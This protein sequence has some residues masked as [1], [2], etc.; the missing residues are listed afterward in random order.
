MPEYYFIQSLHTEKDYRANFAKIRDSRTTFVETTVRH[1]DINHGIYIDIFPLDDCYDDEKRQQKRF[2]KQIIMNARILIGFCFKNYK[3]TWPLR[4]ARVLAVASCIFYPTVRSALMARE[5]WMQKLPKSNTYANYCSA[6]FKKEIMPK[7]WF[8]EGA[9]LEFEGMEVK[10]PKEYDKW[11]TRVYG[12]YMQLPPEE[13]RVAHHFADV[14]DPDTP[15]TFYK[16][17]IDKGN[18]KKK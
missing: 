17:N 1:C 16:N 13:K 5:K 18:E 9:I 2:S 12:D 11:L 10:V 15:Y 8:G 4:V 6:W 14:I 7:E 3:M